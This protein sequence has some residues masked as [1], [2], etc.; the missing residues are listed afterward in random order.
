MNDLSKPEAI[1]GSLS[2]RSSC[3]QSARAFESPISV[4]ILLSVA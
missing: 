2:G 3:L 1:A 4:L